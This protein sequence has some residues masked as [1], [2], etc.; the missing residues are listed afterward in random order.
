MRWLAE[1]LRSLVPG[2]KVT[3][4]PLRDVFRQL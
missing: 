2:V 3:H 4:V 1:W